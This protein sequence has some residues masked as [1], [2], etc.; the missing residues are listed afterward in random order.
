M[1]VHLGRRFAPD[2]RDRRFL[3]RDQLDPLREQYFPKGIPP[4]SR[5]YRPGPVLNQGA[6]GTC[7]AHGWTAKANAAPIMQALPMTPFALYRSIVLLDEWSDNDSEATAPDADLQNGTS[8]RAGAKAMQQLGLLKQYLWADSVEDVRAWHL[9]GFGGVV[10]GIN[11]TS[12]MFTPDHLSYIGDPEGG[13][14]IVTTGWNDSVTHNGRKVR[15]VRFQNSWSAGWGQG[16]RAWIEE[17]DL[18][19]LLADQG[20]ACA[21]TELKRVAVPTL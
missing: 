11:W 9:A 8:V 18:A 10:L 4:G 16:G 5:H 12:A 13:H 21:A 7:V 19:K 14:C 20:E 6:T 2:P 3:M 1:N 15:A 17:G